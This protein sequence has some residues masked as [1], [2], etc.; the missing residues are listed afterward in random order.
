MGERPFVVHVAKLRRVPGTRWHEVRLGM[1]EDLACPA[2]AVPEG[3]QV[4]VDVT[5][6][7]VAGGV[8]V[9]GTI[10][11]RWA[12]E[13]R[14]CLAK[15]SGGLEVR[16]L[17]HYTEGGDG[18]DTYPLVGDDVDLEPM[19]HDAVLLELP[20]APLCSADCLGL[21]PICGVDRNQ[22]SCGCDPRAPD[23]RWAALG[24]LRLAD[25]GA[26]SAED[27]PGR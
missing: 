21:C 18:S 22:E 17:E 13:C 1:I 5:L 26:A 7:S 14:R 4:E 9:A 20:Q 12:G 25:A 16:V 23:P 6:E 27:Q 8:S 19:A 15:A 2:T 11:S 24:A 3:A 10:R